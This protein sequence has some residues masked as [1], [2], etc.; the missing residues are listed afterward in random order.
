MNNSMA[1]SDIRFTFNGDKYVLEKDP[2]KS[3]KGYFRLPD[4]KIYKADSFDKLVCGEIHA[5]EN[6]SLPEA[7]QVRAFTV[8]MNGFAVEFDK[9]V[10]FK[11]WVDGKVKAKDEDV[12]KFRSV[13]QKLMN[14]CGFSVT[15]EEFKTV[16]YEKGCFVAKCKAVYVG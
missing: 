4:G 3:D 5:I 11:I 8:R 2:F 15:V 14:D 7:K 16:D 9:G 10:P 13:A 1:S 6:I 12:K